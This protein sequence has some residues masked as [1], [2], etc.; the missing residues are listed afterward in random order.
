MSYPALCTL[1]I[2]M[3][4]LGSA[5]TDMYVPSLPQIS[6]SFSAEPSSVQL[7]ISL[8]LI[9][10]AMGQLLYGPLLDRF[11][12]RRGALRVLWLGCFG[13]LLSA[14][15]TKLWILNLGRFLQGTGFSAISVAVPAIA[16][17]QRFARTASLLSVIFGLGPLL[18]P[19]IG[20][21]I[22]HLYGWQLIFTLIFCYSLLVLFAL[23]WMKDDPSTQ[24]NL[25]SAGW[26]ELRHSYH[27]ILSHRQFVANALAK[28]LA[29]SGAMVFFSISPFVLHKQFQLNAVSYGWFTLSLSATILLAKIANSL[30]IG[31]LTLHQLNGIALIF[32]NLAPIALLAISLPNTQSLPAL[33]IPLALFGS[34]AGL[35]FSNTTSAMFLPFPKTWGGRVAGLAGMIQMLSAFSGTMIATCVGTDTFIPLAG[36]MLGLSAIAAA[37]YYGLTRR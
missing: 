25:A 21:Y 20:G 10:F 34:G 14:V 22:S 4:L 6:Q 17:D 3:G 7:S 27:Q 9:A 19:I 18:A 5:A 26:A 32:I 13:A 36:V 28:S 15:A 24:P 37:C 2:F 33:L 1:L 35:L 8:Y 31:R 11:G 23:T 16:R 29:F 30:L 12:K